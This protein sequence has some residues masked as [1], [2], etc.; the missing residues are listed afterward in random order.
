MLMRLIRLIAWLGAVLLAFRFVGPL[1]G[2]FTAAVA[3]VFSYEDRANA[4]GFAPFKVQV[5][6]TPDLLRETGIATTDQLAV[7]PP[8]RDGVTFT[9]LRLG[10]WSRE[11]NLIFWDDTCRFSTELATVVQFDE[12]ERELPAGHMRRRAGIAT[13]I[14]TLTIERGLKCLEVVVE[15]TGARSDRRRVAVIPHCLFDSPRLRQGKLSKKRRAKVL[16]AAGWTQDAPTDL[17]EYG[18]MPGDFHHKYLTVST[19]YI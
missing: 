12:F 16:E 2:T 10:L 9:V 3:W 5:M 19:H 4:F 18:F 15:S 14:P 1:A 8:R 7:R 17:G 11:A 13:G 6:F